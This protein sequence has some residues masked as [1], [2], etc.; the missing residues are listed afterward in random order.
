MANVFELVED[1]DSVVVLKVN[2]DDPL[3]VA[4]NPY[5]NATYDYISVTKGENHILTIVKKDGS[6]FSFHWGISGYTLICDELE[7][8]RKKVLH[9]IKLCDIKIE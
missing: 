9:T 3:T 2:A 1:N 8:L 6:T 7:L 4:L 5:V